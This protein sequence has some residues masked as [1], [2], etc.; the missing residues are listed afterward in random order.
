MGQDTHASVDDATADDRNIIQSDLG[1]KTIIDLRTKTEHIKQTKEHRARV[2]AGLVTQPLRIEGV[3]YRDIRVTGRAFERHL[4]SQLSWPSFLRVI[5]LFIF[6][7]RLDAISI[8]G[9]EVMIPRGLIGLGIDT[10]DHS[11]KEIREALSLYAD[12]QSLPSLV[13][14][15]QGKDRTGLIA[16]LVLMIL[17]V[18]V[19]AIERDYALTDEALAS[20]REDRLVEIR[21]IGLTDEWADTDKNM[22]SAVVKH[23][24]T[25]YGGLDGYLDDIGFDNTARANVRSTLLY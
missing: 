18:P 19:S 3:Q 1:I 14:C 23:L 4:L 25:H 11:K 24:E 22:I 9:R 10:L 17:D 12:P 8:I 2:Q 7:H 15:T 5:F 20:D 13:H 6:G 21:Q 16:S